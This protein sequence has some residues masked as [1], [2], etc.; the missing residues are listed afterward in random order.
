M[1]KFLFGDFNFFPS[2]SVNSESISLDLRSS[3]SPRDIGGDSDI[4]NHHVLLDKEAKEILLFDGTQDGMEL[5]NIDTKVELIVCIANKLA[6][7]LAFQRHINQKSSFVVH[8]LEEDTLFTNSDCDGL[9]P[10]I[11]QDLHQHLDGMTLR[12]F[13]E[14]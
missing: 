9:G 12:S 11:V 2:H 5:L 10:T 13:G 8:M 6:K 4:Q 7:V 3:F 1:I 14:E